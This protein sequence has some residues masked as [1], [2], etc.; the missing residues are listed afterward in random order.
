VLFLDLAVEHH[1][2]PGRAWVDMSRR[3]AALGYRAVRVDNLGVGDSPWTDPPEDPRCYTS[4]SARDAADAVAYFSAS[5][6]TTVVGLCSGGWAAAVAG[7][8]TPPTSMYLVNPAMWKRRMKPM[9]REDMAL[10][11][12]RWATASTPG[13]RLRRRV[14][15][16]VRR[17]APQALD[18][19]RRL[20][21]ATRRWLPEPLWVL[22]GTL[23]L[24]HAPV[25]LLKPLLR[26]GVDVH[27][28]LGP[29][30]GRALRQR[31][32]RSW[33]RLTGPGSIR[34][35]ELEYCDHALLHERSRRQLSDHLAATLGQSHPA[36]RREQG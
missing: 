20:K 16:W 35:D 4:G 28:V 33:Q 24:V 21:A 22:A 15:A 8:L 26:L 2:G 9:G 29:T 10:P 7:T 25:V 11:A 23:G 17:C 31:T 27:V 36:T 30:D 34:L 3:L 19:K 13:G 5:G 1:I 14:A 6:D 32:A 18:M 12:D